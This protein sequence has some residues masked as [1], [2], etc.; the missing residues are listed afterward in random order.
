MTQVMF[1]SAYRQLTPTQRAFVDNTVVHIEQ[2]A[3]RANERITMA[4]NRPVPAE[5]VARSHGMLDNHLVQAAITE[6]INEIAA[7]QE[8][9]AARW[10]KQLRAIAFSNIADFMRPDGD[11]MVFDL[12]RATPEQWSAVKSFEI[13]GGDDDGFSRKKRKIKLTLW[14]KPAAIKMLGQYMALLEPDNPHWKADIARVQGAAPLP[15]GA[16]AEDAGAEYQRYL[17]T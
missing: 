15:A 2:A 14:D 10:V 17:G 8:L 5:I 9:T 12:S 7:E 13:E 6:R 3:A 4:L 11:D 1:Q 16:T